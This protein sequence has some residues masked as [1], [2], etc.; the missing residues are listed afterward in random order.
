MMWRHVVSGGSE[1]MLNLQAIQ[2]APGLLA[3]DA[4]V[5]PAA[6]GTRPLAFEDNASLL[7]HLQ[8]LLE[9]LEFFPGEGRHGLQ[10]KSVFRVLEEQLDRRSGGLLL[11]V[12]VIQQ[13]CIEIVEGAIDPVRGTR[14]GQVQH[15]L[16]V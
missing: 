5:Q 6:V 2:Q 13:H 1:A 10:E 15:G 4:S 9:V 16:A 8:D 3:T 7:E 11:A 14:R 12:R